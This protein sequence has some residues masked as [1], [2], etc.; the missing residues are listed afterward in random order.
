MKGQKQAK[1]KAISNE[2]IDEL[3]K[4]KIESRRMSITF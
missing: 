3:L 2:M 1:G 4:N